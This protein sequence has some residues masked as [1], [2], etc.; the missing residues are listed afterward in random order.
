MSREFLQ[1][2]YGRYKD[3][4]DH[5]ATWLFNAGARCG[6]PLAQ[7]LV[8]SEI[9]KTK[10]ADFVAI[11]N[12]V[13]NSQIKMPIS[14]LKALRRAIASRKAATEWYFGTGNGDQIAN[15]HHTNF[16]SVLERICKRLEPAKDI[17]SAC[18]PVSAASTNTR[19]DGVKGSDSGA[20]ASRFAALFVE[21]LE[22]DPENI[23]NGPP[24]STKPVTFDV[25]D[26]DMSKD[27]D[28]EVS[29]RAYFQAFC[30]FQDLQ[31]IRQ[32][33]SNEWRGY[34]DRKLDA[35]T[36]SVVTDTALQF[37]SKMIEDFAKVSTLCKDNN[38]NN[39][40][41]DKVY[42]SIC[43]ARGIDMANTEDTA[44]IA[45][46]CFHPITA[47]LR[48]LFPDVQ[49][50]QDIHAA[51]AFLRSLLTD[52][53]DINARISKYLG[54]KELALDTRPTGMAESEAYKS[55]LSSADQAILR[56]MIFGGEGLLQKSP[57]PVQDEITN[58]LTNFVITKKLTT[59]VCFATQVLL[60]VAR[61]IKPDDSL[62]SPV[63]P[64]EDLRE[65]GGRINTIIN[66]FR[67]LC[68]TPPTM[69][70][71]HEEVLPSMH[72]IQSDIQFL[73]SSNRSSQECKFL[74]QHPLLCGLFTFNLN[75]R[76]QLLGLKMCWLPQQLAFLYISFSTQLKS[77]TLLVWPDMETFIAIHGESTVFKGNRPKDRLHSA[78]RLEHVLRMRT[79][80]HSEKAPFKPTSSA[81]EMFRPRYTNQDHNRC[82]S[83]TDVANR[84]TDL[85]SNRCG[86]EGPLA[87]VQD[88][89]DL[90]KQCLNLIKEALQ[91]DEAKTMFDYFGL[92]R[93]C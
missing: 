38:N 80:F 36:A 44:Q 8:E 66:D 20:C 60:D 30:F 2:S 91:E 49:D 43:A 21:E 88:P 53:L 10:V 5:F 6:H 47:F 83:I 46:S 73:T 62:D 79:F 22:S 90:M 82:F 16:T 59:S 68:T 45:D 78:G 23:P 70:Q 39:L 3:D 85:S 15:E 14:V 25:V 31:K 72:K 63:H 67:A 92:Y 57:V 64:F 29:S 19:K 89:Q 74:L 17:L 71:W 40:L 28:S 11:S 75:V 41:Q 32:I 24:T 87:F 81:T 54:D 37:A 86:K 58:H 12:A 7:I 84:M 4:T 55:H 33:I 9:T 50:L 18:N 13:S 26:D 1:G 35:V 42:F 77:N 61:I 76:M 51:T 65:C 34:R 27:D 56:G 48:S 52:I 69:V 93:C